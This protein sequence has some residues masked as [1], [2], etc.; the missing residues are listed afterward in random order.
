M[1]ITVTCIVFIV[2]LAKDSNE[3]GASQ[4]ANVLLHYVSPPLVVISWLALGP[5]SRLG[6]ADIPR[7][8]LWPLIWIV[9]TLIYGAISGWY[10]YG[11]VD[12]GAH[13]YPGVLATTLVI[14]AFAIGV[15]V[16]YIIAGRLRWRGGQLT[17]KES[18]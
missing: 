2:M 5:D 4:V 12:A 9:Y 6:F 17:Q 16:F 1:G 11:F 10:P 8:M 14:V 15:A 7:V 13:G 18:A 3:T